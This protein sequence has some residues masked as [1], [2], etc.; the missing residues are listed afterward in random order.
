[1]S[2]YAVT[3]DFGHFLC[4]SSVDY[5]ACCLRLVFN[6]HPQRP[7]M[8]EVHGAFITQTKSYATSIACELAGLPGQTSK[9]FVVELGPV[10]STEVT[11][12]C[13]NT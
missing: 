13:Q 3:D 12:L 7:V 9:I 2:L 11:E 8:G 1:M 6:G 10:K 4:T 5:H